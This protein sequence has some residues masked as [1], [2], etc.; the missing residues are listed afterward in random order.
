MTTMTPKWNY[1]CIG[2]FT[3]YF[4]TLAE[5]VKIKQSKVQ[6]LCSNK[7]FIKFNPNGVPF[8]HSPTLSSSVAIL[9]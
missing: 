3:N 5:L 4:I 1:R 2:V 7:C 6:L 8:V 9:Y